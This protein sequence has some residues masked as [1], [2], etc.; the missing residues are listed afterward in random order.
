M[1]HILMYS[2]SRK[3]IR[4][5]KVSHQS[6]EVFTKQSN[7][8]YVT[9]A[10]E[11]ELVCLYNIEENWGNDS[12]RHRLFCAKAAASTTCVK[13][14]CLPHSSGATMY[15]SMWQ[16]ECIIRLRVGIQH[17]WLETGAPCKQIYHGHLQSLA[18][19][20]LMQMQRTLHNTSMFMPKAL[21]DM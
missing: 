4:K 7:K 10:G 16:G 20:N 3:K 9:N 6:A 14:R 5:S 1:W 15:H 13:P 12:L 2:W 8:E 21:V 11:K 19:S 18:W 17:S